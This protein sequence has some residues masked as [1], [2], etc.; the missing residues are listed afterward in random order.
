MARGFHIALVL[1]LSV[2]LSGAGA[3]ATAA[4]GTDECATGAESDP[5][6]E[7]GVPCTACIACPCAHRLLGA[8]APISSWA[9]VLDGGTIAHAT[10]SVPAAPPPGR[11]FQPPRA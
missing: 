5:C 6:D 7:S 1:A 9:V 3:I 10:L 11:L 4:W 8:V 2:S